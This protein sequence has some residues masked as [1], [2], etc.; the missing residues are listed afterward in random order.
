[1]PAGSPVGLATP[2][3]YAQPGHV[4]PQVIRDVVAWLAEE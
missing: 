4:D 3:A 2:A 1:V